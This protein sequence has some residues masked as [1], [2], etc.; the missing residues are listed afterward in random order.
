MPKVVDREAKRQMILNAAMR[1]FARKGVM[2]TKAID[3]AEEAGV[4][5]G[6][7]YEYFRSKEEIFSAAFEFFFQTLNINIERSLAE[8]DD[9]VQKLKIIIG[10][11]MRGFLQNDGKF[12]ELIMEFWA[13]GVRTKDPAMLGSID[14]KSLYAEYRKFISEVIEEG[15]KTG[16]FR[17]IDTQMVAS[18]IIAAL[19]GIGLQW[20]MDR[21]LFNPEKISELMFATL[22][23]GIRKR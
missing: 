17:K 12:A 7:I 6:T 2:K 18:V 20:I 14:L 4:G 11:T 23:E 21:Q 13:E 10:E 8:T 22:L 3:I 9:P 1:A 15:I 19:D 16:T 5:K